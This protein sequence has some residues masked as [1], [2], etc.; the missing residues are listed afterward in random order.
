LKDFDKIV[1]KLQSGIGTI[2]MPRFTMSNEN[3]L[4]KDLK[5]LGMATAFDPHSADFQAM[6]EVPKSFFIGQ[7]LHK[8]IMNVNEAGTEAAAV[9]AIVMATAAYMPGKPFEMNV[10]RPF[11]V[12]IREQD[13]KEIL[14]LGAVLSP[15]KLA[16]PKEVNQSGR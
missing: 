6:A 9:T 5:S 14:F 1:D 4:S 12:A 16:A 13:T 2:K 11:V 7:V 3:E 10:D 15:E 8:T